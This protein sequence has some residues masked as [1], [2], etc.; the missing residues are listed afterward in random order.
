MPGLPRDQV[1]RLFT[2]DI[3][4]RAIVPISAILA[5]IVV[6]LMGRTPRMAAVWAIVWMISIS[7]IFSF[8]IEKINMNLNLLI[9][10]LSKGFTDGAGLAAILATAG[11]C[12]GVIYFTGIGMKFSNLVLSI[13][14][15]HLLLA[16]FSLMI[17]ALFLGMGLPT[18]AAYLILAIMAGPALKKL[19]LPLLSSHLMIFYYAVFAGITP[20]VGIAYMTAAGIAGAKQLKT[21]ITAFKIAGMGIL[22]PFLWI[23]KPG[24]ILH[25]TIGMSLWS[26]FVALIGVWFVAITIIGFWKKPLNIA[27]RLLLGGFSLWMLFAPFL[28][29]L[30]LVPAVIFIGLCNKYDFFK[31][32]RKLVKS[33]DLTNE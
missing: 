20:P 12:V 16:L 2:K 19:G 21:G 28:Y 25:D 13:G 6:L 23:Y 14:E 32:K 18:P 15:T 10:G 33:G 26:I 29:Q 9:K 5:I 17:A 1:P 31:F 3:L 27:H 22:M 4:G 30:I 8:F 7:F 24:I 11:I